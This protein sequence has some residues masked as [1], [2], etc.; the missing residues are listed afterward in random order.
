MIVLDIEDTFGI[1]IFQCQRDKRKT[2][3]TA[4]SGRLIAAGGLM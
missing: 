1:K 3:L 2:A 4:A